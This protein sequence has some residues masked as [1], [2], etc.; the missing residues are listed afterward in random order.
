V[1]SLCVVGLD[2]VVT[3][4]RVF[5]L[6]RYL[7]VVPGPLPAAALV[8]R[9]RYLTVADFR[10]TAQVFDRGAEAAARGAAR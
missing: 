9:R 4:A 1:P 2:P 8:V 5:W 7:V 10:G 6:T 3:R